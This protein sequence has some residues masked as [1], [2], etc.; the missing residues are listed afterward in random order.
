VGTVLG[1]FNVPYSSTGRF[2]AF[3]GNSR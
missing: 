2:T 3:G 1:S